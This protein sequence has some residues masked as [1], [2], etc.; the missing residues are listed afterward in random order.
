MLN[1]KYKPNKKLNKLD[2]ANLSLN[3]D[4]IKL[5]DKYQMLH[6]NLENNNHLDILKIAQNLN[7]KIECLNLKLN[8]SPEKDIKTE[9]LKQSRNKNKFILKSKLASRLSLANSINLNKNSYNTNEKSL[10]NSNANLLEKTRN[11]SPFYKNNQ[12]YKSFINTANSINVNNVGSSIKGKSILKST[13]KN[14]LVN[15]NMSNANNEKPASAFKS[16]LNRNNNSLSK[17]AGFNLKCIPK[18]KTNNCSSFVSPNKANSILILDDKSSNNFFKLND[19]Y[20]KDNEINSSNQENKNTSFSKKI[21]NI[22]TPKR[23]INYTKFDNIIKLNEIEKLNQSNNSESFKENIINTN[24]TISTYQKTDTNLP[25]L[26]EDNINQEQSIEYINTYSNETGYS[27]LKTEPNNSL[28]K[29][30]KEINFINN[31][32]DSDNIKKTENKINF[33]GNKFKFKKSIHNKV[34]SFIKKNC[35]EL[36][37]YNK[38]YYN[39][40]EKKIEEINPIVD[41]RDKLP[42]QKVIDD[43]MVRPK[44]YKKRYFVYNPDAKG[45]MFISEDR[46][47]EDVMIKAKIISSLADKQVLKY[48]DFIADQFD[49]KV[50][51][52]ENDYILKKID[53]KKD[54]ETF[55]EEK[56]FELE[57]KKR[58]LQTLLNDTKNIKNRVCKTSYLKKRPTLILSNNIKL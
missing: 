40:L 24:Q 12:M 39:H 9:I 47:S 53:I 31:N 50:I 25:F 48:K 7:R 13:Q 57:K 3:H 6:P 16:L 11:N 1:Q 37:D 14:K 52:T 26:T 27:F 41:Y 49:L 19:K 51:K 44:N 20:N 58:E 29:L 18:I 8:F 2:L 5:T 4:C 36:R 54:I 22:Y 56:F 28:S 38:S 30:R 45:G 32:E 15:L 35:D 33:Y 55:K 42:K 21:N 23:N 43:D 34:Y 10:I 46:K 17:P